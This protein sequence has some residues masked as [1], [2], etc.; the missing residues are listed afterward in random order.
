MKTC[1]KLLVTSYSRDVL[2]CVTRE[3]SAAGATEISFNGSC[4]TAAVSDTLKSFTPGLPEISLDTAYSYDENLSVKT[5][6][7]TINGAPLPGGVSSFDYDPAGRLAASTRSFGTIAYSYD[8]ADR[9]TELWRTLGEL[10]GQ[11][12][13]SVVRP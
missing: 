5:V 2:G 1:V 4:S 8:T 7:A 12:S 6:S 3:E 9:T 13:N 10:C 11:T